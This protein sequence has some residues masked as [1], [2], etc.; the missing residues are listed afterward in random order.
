MV[1]KRKGLVCFVS[2]NDAIDELNRADGF[3]LHVTLSLARASI[4]STTEGGRSANR[5]AARRITDACCRHSLEQYRLGRTRGP[6]PSKRLV[7]KGPTQAVPPSCS[8]ALISLCTTP[9]TADLPFIRVCGCLTL[10]AIVHGKRGAE[11]SR[12][13]HCPPCRHHRINTKAIAKA[14]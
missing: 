11:S 1:G 10:P 14:T 12:G 9:K 3:A 5:T 4:A 2:L 13:N 6:L 7:Q 8:D